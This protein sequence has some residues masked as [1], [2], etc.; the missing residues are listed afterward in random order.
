MKSLVSISILVLL[1]TV[2]AYTILNLEILLA[3]LRTQTVFQIGGVAVEEKV[4]IVQFLVADPNQTQLC[5]NVGVLCGACL[6][7]WFTIALLNECSLCEFTH[8]VLALVSSDW[9]S[10]IIIIIKVI[11][12]ICLS[13][14]SDNPSFH[15]R[16]FGYC[17]CYHH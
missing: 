3:H 16:V 13:N 12:L 10:F 14:L 5:N 2:N 17:N 7:E 8:P 15:F 11:W 4:S 1:V 6:K 9:Y